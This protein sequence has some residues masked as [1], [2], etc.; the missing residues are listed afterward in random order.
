MFETDLFLAFDPLLQE[1]EAMARDI[2][3]PDPCAVPCSRN[4]LATHQNSAV[5][6]SKGGVAPLVVVVSTLAVQ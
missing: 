4:K 2:T 3:G 6:D 5:E 1:V